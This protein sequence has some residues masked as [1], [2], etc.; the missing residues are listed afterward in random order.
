VPINALEP[1]DVVFPGGGSPQHVAMYIGGGQMVEA[2]Q[3]GDVVKVSPLSNLGDG[4]EA[5]RF[6]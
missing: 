4:I 2:P 1:G 6:G 3:S 5:R